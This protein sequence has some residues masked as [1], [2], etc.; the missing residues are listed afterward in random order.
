MAKHEFV[1]DAA[2][3]TGQ[4]GAFQLDAD[5]AWAT[6]LGERTGRSAGSRG[7]LGRRTGWTTRN[8]TRLVARLA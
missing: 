1:G 8:T 4:V 6:V 3:R 5:L 2:L 7:A